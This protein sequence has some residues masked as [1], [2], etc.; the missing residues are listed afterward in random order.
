MAS[1]SWRGADPTQATPSSLPR[2]APGWELWS[3]PARVRA[4]WG[5]G[6]RGRGGSAEPGPASARRSLA[7]AHAHPHLALALPLLLLCRPGRLETPRPCADCPPS[8]VS[9]AAAPLCTSTSTSTRLHH[10]RRRLAHLLCNSEEGNRTGGRERRQLSRESS[11]RQHCAALA[12]P[13]ALPHAQRHRGLPEKV[14]SSRALHT[15]DHPVDGT[16]FPTLAIGR[17]IYTDAHHRAWRARTVCSRSCCTSASRQGV[18]EATLKDVRQILPRVTLLQLARPERPSCPCSHACTRALSAALASTVRD[19]RQHRQRLC[20]LACPE[21]SSGICPRRTTGGV[22]QH[23]H[24]CPGHHAA[25]APSS[26]PSVAA[27]L[28]ARMS[29]LIRSSVCS[30][31]RILL[32]GKAAE[33]GRARRCGRREGQ[34]GE[35]RTS[36]VAKPHGAVLDP[37]A[38]L[39]PVARCSMQEELM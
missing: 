1:A 38:L 30:T 27:D 12:Y 18:E 34:V 14:A 2:L 19:Q 13:A 3:R 16:A 35:E 22:C 21:P 24:L 37:L 32:Q 33:K 5:L 8:T 17:V 15:S 26:H 20:S 6:G 36:F 29:V 39:G 23:V 9:H 31:A 28:R 11:W 10:T 7:P 25:V 4:R